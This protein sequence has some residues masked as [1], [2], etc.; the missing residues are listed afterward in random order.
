MMN[1]RASVV[2]RSPTAPL[3]ILSAQFIHSG[4]SNPATECQ[5][6]FRY[7]KIAATTSSSETISYGTTT[8]STSTHHRSTRRWKMTKSTGWLHSH[9]RGGSTSWLP[10][11]AKSKVSPFKIKKLSQIEI[12]L[13]RRN[14]DRPEN[15]VRYITGQ[16]H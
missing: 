14:S 7:W 2:S 12:S 5:R 10:G 3:K 16:S 13:T 11:A 9:S 15:G 1:C 8:S 6:L 4:R